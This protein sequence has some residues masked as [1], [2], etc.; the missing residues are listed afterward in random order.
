HRERR[1]PTWEVTNVRS[2]HELEMLLLAR[3]KEVAIPSSDPVNESYEEAGTTSPRN[4]YRRRRAERE[5][6]YLQLLMLLSGEQMAGIKAEFHAHDDEV[7]LEDFCKIMEKY[8]PDHL[9]QRATGEG[10]EKG[11]APGSEGKVESGGEVRQGRARVSQEEIMSNLV[12]LFKEVDINGD[13]MMEWDEFTRFVVE[14]AQ[15]HHAK[16]TIDQI[17]E[18]TQAPKQLEVSASN[19]SCKAVEQLCYVPGSNHVAVIQEHNPIINVYH[20]QTCH[21]VAELRNTAVPLTMT[22]CSNYHTLITASADMT[23]LHWNLDDVPAIKHYTLRS[24]WPT[25]QAIMSMC[26][27]TSHQLLYS[28]TTAGTIQGWDIDERQEMVTL[29]G[30]SDIV[31]DIVMSSLDNLLSASL[32]TSIR[33]WDTYTEKPVHT[34]L[35]HN[36]GV[37][38]LS[39]SSAH[40]CLVSAGFDHEAHVWSPFVNSL[41]YKLKG[42]TASLV[43]CQAV[44]NTPELITA[45]SAGFI[46]VWDLRTFHCVQTLQPEMDVELTKN[47]TAT[48]SGTACFM[49]LKIPPTRCNQES[50][51]RERADL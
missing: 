4:S 20:A 42:H 50:A 31:M 10:S 40:R 21:R 47:G 32:D 5:Q 44:E 27:S 2:E 38:S 33:I 16:L 6:L 39:Y 46:K 1:K 30:H 41:L 14:K 26:W 45:D 48:T 37:H 7:D 19:R 23:V 18:Y 17:Q 9:V 22:Y 34:L 29:K 15:L 3:R 25:K 11:T 8:Q 28:G 49:H 13:G 51:S 35:G 12:E 24:R 43:G 36:K